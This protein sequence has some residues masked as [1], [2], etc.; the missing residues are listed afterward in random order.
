MIEVKYEQPLNYYTVDNFIEESCK[1]I[2]APV[3]GVTDI[4]A[5]YE[6]A[7]CQ[8]IDNYTAAIGDSNPLY[9]D[10]NYAVYR[11][12][13]GTVIAPP[14][15]LTIFK[16]PISRGALF[17]GPYPLVG[18][19]AEFEWEWNDVIHMNDKFTSELIL[20]NVCERPSDKGRTV[21]LVSE[22][23]YFNKL[24]K[25]LIAT[26]HGTYAAIA[27]V[28]RITDIPSAIKEGFIKSPI[29][30]RKVYHYSDEEVECIVKDI[31]GV[32]RRGLTPLYWEDVN[33]GD[34]LPQVVKAP[35]TTAALMTYHGVNF[36]AETFP[37]FGIAFRKWLK[38]PGFLRMNPLTGWP[39]DI[40]MTAHGDPNLA[41][42]VGM[43]YSFGM[44]SLK[45]GLCAHLLTNWMGDDGFIRRMKVD[46]LEPYIYGDALWIRGEVVDKY[47]EKL[48]GTMYSAVDIKIE[49]VNQLGQNIAPGTAT[50][51]LPCV[52]SIVELPIP[53]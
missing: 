8:F 51:Y 36:S 50:I 17:D 7:K 22:C 10:L 47:K 23:K 19:E 31:E 14:T 44:G 28:E 43:P 2:G 35:L 52:N 27:R 53:P 37:T 32:A 34:K 41:P 11:S 3:S 20:K 45:V 6:A 33:I 25:G 38:S 5:R 46:T 30:G 24:S 42:S 15:F 16:Y 18:L 26:C 21:Y 48:G 4:P 29:T 40:Q 49:A 12:M 39:Y 13:Y 9:R 1:M